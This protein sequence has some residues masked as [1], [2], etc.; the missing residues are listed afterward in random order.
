VIRSLYFK[1]FLCFCVVSILVRTFIVITAA[2][3][4]RSVDPVWLTGALDSYARTAVN[5]YVR[6]G[7]AGLAQNLDEIEKSARIRATL[8]DPKSYDILERGVPAEAED[9]LDEAQSLGRS[10]FRI[11]VRWRGVSV[12]STDSGNYFFVAEIVPPPGAVLRTRLLRWTALLLGGLLCLILA[13]HITKPIRGLQDVAGRIANGDL[14]VRALPSI[15][16]RN[17]ELADLARDFDRM[18]DRIAGLLRKQQEMLGDISHELRSPLTRLGVSLEL[19]RRGETDGVERMQADLNSL[20]RL[21]HQILTLTRLQACGEQKTETVLNLRTIVEGVAEDADFEGRQQGKSVVVGHAD[22]CWTKGDPALLRSCIENVV[23]NAVRHTN[24]KTG[25]L[26]VL[27]E[28]DY[29]NLKWA[30][31]VVADHGT[32]VP[33][34]ALPRLFEP[35]YRVPGSYEGKSDS[36][37]LG[38]SIAQRVAALYGGNITARNRAQGGLEMLIRLPACDGAT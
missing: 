35:F 17:D 31:L 13:R 28:T 7:R 20:N 14:S 15:S 21:I 32:G 36:S 34:H 38:L 10:R 8:L 12:I 11:G 27:N 4:S 6:D 29:G 25:V 19:L 9:V 24:S 22:D 3:E 2:I 16:P 37:G 1:I 18:A 23:R 5:S 26:I 33:D 30:C